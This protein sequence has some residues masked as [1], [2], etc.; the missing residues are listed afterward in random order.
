MAT[1]LAYARRAEWTTSHA[2][3]HIKKNNDIEVMAA[4]L[5]RCKV[6]Q[7]VEVMT[8]NTF[9]EPG[10]KIQ[11]YLI[12][13]ADHLVCLKTLTLSHNFSVLVKTVSLLLGKCRSLERAEFHSV[14]CGNSIA[15]W[16]DWI[17]G[18]RTNIRELTLKYGTQP[19]PKTGTLL[20]LVNTLLPTQLLYESWLSN[21]SRLCC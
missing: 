12:R 8:E 9:H 17:E 5:S 14:R 15:D 11:D 7:C 18:D 10:P 19:R 16:A 20:N 2:K 6:L 21:L 4:L 3:F 1:A 13:S